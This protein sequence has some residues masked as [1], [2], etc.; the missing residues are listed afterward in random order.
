MPNLHENQLTLTLLFL[1]LLLSSCSTPS[2]SIS[3]EESLISSQ[4]SE[5]SISSELSSEE[6]SSSLINTSEEESSQPVTSQHPSSEVVTT[7]EE[8]SI[9]E[10]NTSEGTSSV[11]YTWPDDV[12]LAMFDGYTIPSYPLQAG[13]QLYYSSDEVNRMIGISIITSHVTAFDD[14]L[15]VLD[16]NI[17]HSY[18]NYLNHYAVSTNSGGNLNVYFNFNE[19]VLTLTLLGVDY[20]YYESYFNTFIY[21]NNP[22]FPSTLIGQVYD[23]TIGQIIPPYITTGSF[24][25]YTGILVGKSNVVIKVRQS[26]EIEFSDYYFLLWDEDWYM[27]GLIM[28]HEYTAR[29]STNS[30]KLDVSYD[31]STTVTISITLI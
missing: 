11:V 12:I 1:T 24:S 13:D 29:D 15:A 28:N 21:S 5:I 16:T 25:F 3:S 6:E 22:S 17:F 2:S 31:G 20:T 27:E 23:E 14:Y 30:V 26:S 10:S 7:S 4:A 9:S 18:V 19:N 8:P